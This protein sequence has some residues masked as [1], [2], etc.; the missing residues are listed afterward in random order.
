MRATA[1][2]I[3][4]RREV[5]TEPRDGPGLATFRSLA[6]ESARARRPLGPYRR[7]D[8]SRLVLAIALTTVIALAAAEW[9]AS[10]SARLTP[11][12]QSD[13]DRFS[14]ALADKDL[15]AAADAWAHAYRSAMGANGDWRGPVAIAEAWQELVRR[16]GSDT[17]PMS[18]VR[19]LYL[20]ALAR[21]VDREDLDGVIVIGSALG[22]LGDLDGVERVVRIA[23]RLA[24]AMRGD[25]RL[26]ALEALEA[27]LNIA[28]Q[29]PDTNW[30]AR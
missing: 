14:L 23:R 21:A 11:S 4:P 7:R 10:R 26:A 12:W 6:W 3:R 9:Q 22:D 25:S 24:V 2:Q 8:A 5:R 27:R 28:Q 29:Q 18:G 16:S 15:D 30:P 13:L 20:T 1:V 19:T 17:P